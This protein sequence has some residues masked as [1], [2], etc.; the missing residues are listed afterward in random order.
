[1]SLKDSLMDGLLKSVNVLHR[2]ILKMEGR[3]W[4]D[5][6]RH[7]DDLIHAWLVP[8]REQRCTSSCRCCSILTRN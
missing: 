5:I 1:M 7:D 2:G 6:A 4:D 3:P 8:R